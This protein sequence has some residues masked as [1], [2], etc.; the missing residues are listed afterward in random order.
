MKPLD[1]IRVLDFT[2]HM[3][4]PYATAA[5][6]DFGADVIKVEGLGGDPSRRTGVDYVGDQSA[7]FLI[8]NRGKRS[9]A[10]DMRRP[11]GLEAVRRLAR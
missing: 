6:A 5:L 7:L 11:E 3:A 10:I 1:G 4:G 8:W 2:R 9:L